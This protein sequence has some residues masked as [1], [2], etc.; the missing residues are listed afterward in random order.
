MVPGKKYELTLD[1]TGNPAIQ[2]HG[3]AF[4][5]HGLHISPS[6]AQ[7]RP[8]PSGGCQREA[9]THIRDLC[10]RQAYPIPLPI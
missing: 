7:G 8:C 10:G 4:H 9:G 5:T 6:G 2:R 1:N 3:A